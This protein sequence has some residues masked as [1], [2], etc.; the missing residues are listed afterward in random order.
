MTKLLGRLDDV[1]ILDVGAGSGFFSK[2]LL[3]HSDAQAAWCVDISYDT[4]SDAVHDGKPIYYRRH[5]GAVE[6]EVVLLMDVLEHVDDDVSLLR[7]YAEKVGAGTRFLISVPA[8]GF[9]W[10][11]HDEFLEHRRR[12]T[13]RQIENTVRQSGLIVEQGMYYFGFVFPIAAAMRIADKC[14]AGGR[15]PR[16][17]LARHGA[18]VNATLAAVCQSELPLLRVNRLAGLTAFCLAKKQ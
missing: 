8:F 16:S 5:V 18:A 10:S 15:P 2:H 3:R 12:Y 17:Q 9:L 13:L 4:E 11:A 1:T 6:A 14:R 7:H